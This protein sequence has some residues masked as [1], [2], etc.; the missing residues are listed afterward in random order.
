M[1]F[2]ATKCWLKT[3]A[4]NKVIVEAIQKRR[5]HKLARVAQSL[6]VECNT[7]IKRNDLWHE[8]LGD[9]SI[10]ALTT[11]DNNSLVESMDLNGNYDLSFCDGCV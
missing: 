9:V 7:K 11:I 6:I 1:E 10:H 2:E 3:F 5:L 4:S 8:K